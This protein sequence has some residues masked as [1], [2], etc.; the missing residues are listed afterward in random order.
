MVSGFVGA[1][2][3]LLV[4]FSCCVRRSDGGDGEGYGCHEGGFSAINSDS[5]RCYV[6]GWGGRDWF[7]WSIWMFRLADQDGW[8]GTVE[9]V[10]CNWSTQ[11]LILG[12]G[13]GDAYYCFC[14]GW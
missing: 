12:S 1:V 10:I 2:A 9:L 6:R 13:G 8:R 3:G 14:F 7:D 11:L 5:R 4:L